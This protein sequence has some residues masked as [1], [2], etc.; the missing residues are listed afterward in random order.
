MRVPVL[1]CA[2]LLAVFSASCGTK[3]N[4]ENS[5]TNNATANNTTANNTTTTNNTV[6]NTA[7]NSTNAPTNN[8]TGLRAERGCDSLNDGHCMM[9]FPS[10]AFMVPNTARETGFE[11]TFGS[12]TL[13]KNRVDA[14]IDPTP[15][16]RLD[17]FGLQA[18]AIAVFPN[19][20]S[21]AFPNEYNVGASMEAS[22]AIGLFEIAG[23][24]A[25]RVPYW[26]DHDLQT[27]DPTKRSIIVHPAVILKSN[28]RYAVAFRNLVDTNGAAIAAG[29]QFQKVLSGDTAA[30]PNLFYRQARFDELFD[31]L[32]T[33]GFAKDD[34]VLAW[35]WVTSSDA[36]RTGMMLHMRDDAL[37]LAG[38]LGPEL[39]VTNV[40][41]F[42]VAENADTALRI[43]G[44]FTVPNYIVQDGP[45]KR[46]NLGA[47]GLPEATGTRTPEFWVNIP[48][49]ALAGPAHET[50]FYGHGLFGKG[51]R[52][53]ADFNSRVANA[54]DLIYYGASLWGM[55]NVQESDDAFAIIAD[56]SNFPSIGDQLHQGFVEWVLLAR[57]VKNRLGSLTDLSSRSVTV[58]TAQMYYS[59][60]SQ[61]GIFGPTF[62][63]LSPD[64]MVGH[65]GVPGHTYSVLL[66]RS[67]DF[68][69]FFAVMRETYPDVVDQLMGLHTIQLLWDQTDSN[70]YVRHLSAMPFD[71]APNRMLFAP[72]K[73]D[74]QVAVTQNEVLARTPD[75]GIG[76]LADYDTIGGR[77]VDLVTPV[78]YPH[79]GS[80][81]V[82]YDF[83]QTDNTAM[84][85]R[86]AWP[87]P[88][89]VPPR[90]GD[91]TTCEAG[92]PV[93]ENIDRAHFGCCHGQCCFDAHELPRRR[94]WHNDQ[95]VSFF[96]GG[97]ITDVCGG[98]GCTPD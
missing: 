16:G 64:I 37:E 7:N 26:V 81:I 84:S 34:L 88:G 41:E 68:E 52:A 76:L 30:D 74:F 94:D 15:Y 59:G 21:S 87:P 51:D 5:A 85:W 28:T 77:T 63:A 2:V 47:D 71:G 1:G 91:Q 13:P 82:L 14:Y 4:S 43:T 93:D 66:H 35:D 6:N 92:C 80:G 11:L 65:A 97:S 45:T 38:A 75:L 23:T 73:G 17:G 96:R 79:S 36:A 60:I 46:L 19:I 89:N 55:S 18:P 56:L 57:A 29:T 24:T 48:H 3:N 83:E 27:D 69:E 20:D 8:T 62:V 90:F 42:T 50:V 78:A 58:D 53:L 31:I 40:E 22:A 12:E 70:S 86:N 39:T 44:T 32:G 10:M 98:D 25:T 54:N 33:A 72:A 61:G 49:S 9:P 95:M 67:V